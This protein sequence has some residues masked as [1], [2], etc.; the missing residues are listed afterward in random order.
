MCV[1]VVFPSLGF[2]SSVLRGVWQSVL[3]D[4]YILLCLRIHDS[5]S[6][7]QIICFVH[8]S[9]YAVNPWLQYVSSFGT[10]CCLRRDYF[11]C[12]RWSLWGW[13]RSCRPPP[14]CRSRT[15]AACAAA[16]H[17]HVFLFVSVIILIL[18]RCVVW[19]FFFIASVIVHVPEA[20][21][22]YGVTAAS[23]SLSLSL[24]GYVGDVNNGVWLVNVAHAHFMRWSSST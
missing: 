20:E 11:L 12:A 19:S 9:Q 4:Q 18:R 15:L 2:Q 23:K 5:I 6:C 10:A 16:G 24:S 13:V 1:D 8:C 22:S 3:P 7:P 17:L 14:R 21:R